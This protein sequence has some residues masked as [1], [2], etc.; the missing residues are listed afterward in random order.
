MITVNESPF[1]RRQLNQSPDA[2]S[3]RPYQRYS[4]TYIYPFCH[5]N[6]AHRLP[7]SPPPPLP[8]LPYLSTLLILVHSLHQSAS[9]SSLNS[10]FAFVVRLTACSLRLTALLSGANNSTTIECPSSPFSLLEGLAAIPVLCRHSIKLKPLA[11]NHRP[12]IS[13]LLSSLQKM[14]TISSQANP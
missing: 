7:Q 4:Y 5:L 6:L 3:P 9:S 8:H 11:W 1:T 13:I 12:P 10:L 14:S 2:R